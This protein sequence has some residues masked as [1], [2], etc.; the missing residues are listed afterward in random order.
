M[1][2][3]RRV[4]RLTWVF[5]LAA[6]GAGILA[7]VLPTAAVL[8]PMLVTV[9]VGS[10]ALASPIMSIIITAESLAMGLFAAM[11]HDDATATNVERLSELAVAGIIASLLAM[12][13]RRDRREILMARNRFALVA[14]NASDV[15]YTAD[16]DRHITWMAPNVE[17]V[18]GWRPQDLM[19]RAVA[20]ILHPEDRAATEDVRT[21]LYAGEAVAIPQQGFVQR[22]RQQ[23]GRYRWMAVRLAP[24]HHDDGAAAGVVGSLTDVDDLVAAR[25]AAESQRALLQAIADASPDPQVLVE[26]RRDEAGQL[27]DLV[28]LDVNEAT[29]HAFTQSREVLVGRG[30]RDLGVGA[31]IDPAFVDAV[32]T[33]LHT[34]ELLAVDG[35]RYVVGDHTRYLDIRGRRLSH[36]RIA[37]TWRD[38]TGRRLEAERLADSEARYRLLAENATDVVFLS[39]AATFLRWVSPSA[40][41]TLGWAPEQ[42]IGL[43]AHDFIHP[44]DRAHVA[45]SVEES[46]RSGA[47]V[48]LRYRWRRPDGSYRW[49]E[50]LGRAFGGD[51]D[52]PPGRVVQLRDIEQ[53]VE[54][55]QE[56]QRRAI[57]DDLTGA[58]KRDAALE[59][60]TTLG[61][62]PRRPGAH[63]GVLFMDLDDFKDVNDTWG[64]AAG[65]LLL[66][67]FV[68]RARTVLRA[69]DTI[70]RMGGDEFVICLEHLHDLAEAA[71]IGEKLRTKLGM[72]VPV[73]DAMLTCTVSVGATLLEPGEDAD[74]VIARADRAMYAAKQ[75]G[76]DRVVTIAPA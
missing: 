54:V 48:R 7:T 47:T 68:E 55:E 62:G 60:L 35:V 15:V 70:A 65:D 1:A 8:S 17:R 71:S 45:A 66:R 59:V 51:G 58:L 61:S 10:V 4:P 50:A 31:A 52:V 16:A 63:T 29:V 5:V 46:E 13:V 2:T 64:H 39:D 53:Q 30:M 22:V 40:A 32:A 49:V 43:H 9:I 69:G 20:D 18:L 75:G 44:E 72:P 23:D 36:E 34:G 14:E 41:T 28:F 73:G 21:R 37:L 12:R 74:H 25:S 6:L 19:G 26:A 42:L 76:R 57:F 38:V 11:V 67:T 56:L 24:L 33:A 27:V 3:R